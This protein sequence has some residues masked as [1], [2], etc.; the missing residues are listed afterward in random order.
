MAQTAT[1]EDA[2]TSPLEDYRFDQLDQALDERGFALMPG[3][4]TSDEC[5]GLSASFDESNLFRSH[6]VMRRYGFGEGEY[7]YFARPLPALVENL[8]ESLYPPFAA[9]ANRWSELLG[10]EK[11]YPGTL[12]EFIERCHA[13]DQTRPTPLL[14]RYRAGDYNRLHQDLYGGVYFPLQLAVLL[15]R[16]GVDFDGGEFVLTEQKPRSQSRVQ[17]VPLR[18]GDAVVFA[19]NDRPVAGSRGYYRVRMRHGVS[20]LRRGWRHTLGVIFHDAR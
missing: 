12:Q 16:P 9:V 11:V 6:V 13:A 10:I 20:E 4:L 2:N 7:K 5:N 1:R 8:R 18:Q 3:L 19:V 15:D 14:L 17:V